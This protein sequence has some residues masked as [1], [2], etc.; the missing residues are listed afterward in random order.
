MSILGKRSKLFHEF[1]QS[2]DLYKVI[3]ISYW[4][5]YS[6]NKQLNSLN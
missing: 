2:N 1:S 3:Q 4:I 5:K 6:V